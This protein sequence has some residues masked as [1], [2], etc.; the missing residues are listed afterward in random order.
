MPPSRAIPN[1]GRNQVEKEI[2]NELR[3]LVLHGVDGVPYGRLLVL[4]QVFRVA[5][6]RDTLQPSLLAAILGLEEPISLMEVRDQ[7][8]SFGLGDRGRLH[9]VRAA[10]PSVVAAESRNLGDPALQSMVDYQSVHH[11]R[12]LAIEM[13]AA[14][15]EPEFARSRSPEVFRKRDGG[16]HQFLR[17]TLANIRNSWLDVRDE[18]VPGRSKRSS[19][20]ASAWAASRIPPPHHERVGYWSRASTWAAFHEIASAN[21]L[22]II[23]G[24]DGE[25][26]GGALSR[27]AIYQEALA[28]RLAEVMPEPA[29]DFSDE[30][31]RR[32][33]AM[34]PSAFLG[35]VLRQLH[36][37]EGPA[38]ERYERALEDRLVGATARHMRDGFL[39]RGV[40]YLAFAMLHA[41]QRPEVISGL[42]GSDFERAVEDRRRQYKRLSDIDL[43]DPSRP[44]R[45]GRRAVPFFSIHG[46]WATHWSQSLVVGEL[47]FEADPAIGERSGASRMERLVHAFRDRTVLLVGSSL[48]DAS[49]LSALAQTADSNKPRYALVLAPDHN[50]AL[51]V[52]QEEEKI[53]AATRW[54][55]AQ[56]YAHLGVVP[57]IAN[58]PS[59]IPQSLRE[60]ASIVERGD[61]SLDY[62]TRVDQWHQALIEHG[63]D[64]NEETGASLAGDALGLV[65]RVREIA[66][67]SALAHD[68]KERID[69]ELW[70]R[71]GADRDRLYRVATS[72]ARPGMV[73]PVSLF[74]RTLDRRTSG[75]LAAEAFRVGHPC[76]AAG[77]TGSRRAPAFLIACDLVRYSPRN[78][79]LGAY[80]LPVG[81][82]VFVS[83]RADGRLYDLSR[84]TL[85]RGDIE[86]D[87]L[88]IVRSALP[89]LPDG[90]NEDKA[91]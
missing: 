4:A 66:A 45:D 62:D 64:F 84:D 7:W 87:L 43:A 14:S 90:P 8:A 36:A 67:S 81:A 52:E 83:N 51:R 2:W 22:T 54:L 88:Q 82:V 47:D 65:D 50:A 37:P 63:V 1:D 59:Q 33:A 6:T 20:A 21:D 72:A 24:T 46:S 57:V 3:Q 69:V 30:A 41:G 16:E 73:T 39:A 13:L 5:P 71:N 53:W 28:D 27:E 11:A 12:L 91:K 74:D 80:R 29:R 70:L 15:N 78:D 55:L 25:Y 68:G 44:T 18:V 10:A 34:V 19:G 85:R 75:A 17:E 35:S 48:S 23:V 79:E 61:S 56:R 76:D 26:D 42:L 86:E 77:D 60:I 58:F 31:L 40:T 89:E 38:R 9:L 49:V 32:V